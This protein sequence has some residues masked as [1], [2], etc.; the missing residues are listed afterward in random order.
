MRQTIFHSAR[1]KLTMFYLLA[2]ILLTLGLNIGARR[3][4][5]YEYQRS[6]FVQRNAIRRLLDR[7]SG[8]P[9]Q[10]EYAKLQKARQ[11]EFYN[12]INQ[13]LTVLSVSIFTIGGIASYWFA[14]RTLRPIEESHEAQKRFAADASHELRTPLTAMRTENE[15][16]LR[17]KD[18][19]KSEA[20]ALIASNLEEVK[21][22]ETLSTSLLALADYET[23]ELKQTKLDVQNVAKEAI[24]QG[25]KLH[26][27][28]KVEIK[29]DIHPAK[30]KGHKDSLVQLVGILLD[31]AY[32]Y[33]SAK[34]KITI[35]GVKNKNSYKL[36]VEDE[37]SG[38]AAKDI[39]HIFERLYRGDKARAATIPGYGL[40]LALAQEI[41]KANNAT[42][43]AKNIPKSGARFT[44]ALNL[45]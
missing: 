8:L 15:V 34:G 11:N 3:L 45:S 24:K 28:S 35:K 12:K 33:G 25:H 38:I 42:L 13:E 40:G 36:S 7:F 31:N 22:L 17:G 18:F 32:K 1:L 20:K 44:I 21:R 16:F 27:G 10:R 5:Q 43:E 39:P 4:V 30:I 29:K 19:S 23:T 41:A 2:V 14:G 9:L 37:G 26:P 6:G